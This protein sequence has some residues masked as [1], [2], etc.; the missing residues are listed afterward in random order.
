MDEHTQ[1]HLFDPFYTTK[2]DG[3]GLGLAVVKSVVESHQGSIVVNSKL[4]QGT[5]FVMSLPSQ[6]EHKKQVSNP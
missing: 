1:K 6:S 3:T 5:V 4:E 2:S